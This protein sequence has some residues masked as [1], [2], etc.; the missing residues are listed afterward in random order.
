MRT[1]IG[2]LAMFFMIACAANASGAAD[3]KDRDA[4]SADYL[5]DGLKFRAEGDCPEAV[6]SYRMA[7]KLDQFREDWIYHLAVADCLVALKQ[8]DD[9]IDSYSK[10]ID[11]TSNRTLQGE[12]HRGRAFA[13]Y[14]KAVTPEAVDPKMLALARKDLDS[15]MELGVDVSDI[16]KNMRDDVEFKHEKEGMK[17]RSLITGQPVTV[18]ES[19]NRM[20]IGDGKYMLYISGDTRINDKKG[21]EIAASDIKPGDLIDFSY[22]ES[23]LNKADGMIHASAKTIT[24]L[25]EVEAKPEPAEAKATQPA[26]D[27][28]EMLILSKINMLA[29]EIKELREKQE[30]AATEPAK[31]KV[32]KRPLRKGAA[33]KKAQ[34][35]KT[36][37]EGEIK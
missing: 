32:K 8:L 19:P 26:Q 37:F 10:V 33:Q 9:A 16:R 17:A 31:P 15:A 14:L 21:S 25:R 18:I 1:T 28:A 20:I 29:D 24:L 13:Y 12:M 3:A 30:A 5:V 34:H 6:K 23:Y 7:R 22:T 35:E 27:A 11:A 36:E 4:H 2:I